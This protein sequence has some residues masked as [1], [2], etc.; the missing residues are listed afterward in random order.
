MGAPL[1]GCEHIT[2]LLFEIFFA[3]IESGLVEVGYIGDTLNVCDNFCVLV[4]D[5]M[6]LSS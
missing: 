3:S 4:T 1:I 5:W 2:A 6:S